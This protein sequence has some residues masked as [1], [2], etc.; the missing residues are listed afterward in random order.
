MPC[1]GKKMKDRRNMFM[2]HFASCGICKL[3]FISE[4]YQ[5]YCP[6]CRNER[7]RKD[8]PDWCFDLSFYIHCIILALTPLVAKDLYYISDRE[9]ERILHELLPYSHNYVQRLMDAI[10]TAQFPPDLSFTKASLEN[11]VQEHENVHRA[12]SF[13]NNNQKEADVLN[14]LLQRFDKEIYLRTQTYNQ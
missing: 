8:N 2:A 6:I 5:R 10:N 4:R 14:L 7:I 9:F 12:F 13:A 1:I 3:P 11:L